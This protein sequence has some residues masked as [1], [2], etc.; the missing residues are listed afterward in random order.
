MRELAEDVL[1]KLDAQRAQLREERRR[2]LGTLRDIQRAANAEIA[3]LEE[4]EEE[5]GDVQGG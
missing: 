3:R 2:H 4:L 5:A 1:A